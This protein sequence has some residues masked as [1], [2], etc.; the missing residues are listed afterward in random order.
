VRGGCNEFRLRRPCFHDRIVVPDIMRRD[1][2]V[3]YKNRGR[4]RLVVE[5]LKRK[6]NQ[7]FAVFLRE[8]SDRTNESGFRTAHLPNGIAAAVVPND[9]T[10]IQS[11]RILK[12]LEGPQ[13]TGVGALCTVGSSALPAVEST[14]GRRKC[15]R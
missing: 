10:M 8:T 11:P 2:V 7:L 14:C 12:C 1:Q 4:H 13:G 5:K 6:C 15:I 9:R 3:L